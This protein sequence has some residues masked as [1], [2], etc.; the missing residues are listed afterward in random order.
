MSVHDQL[1]ALYRVD[2]Q[3]SG[4]SGRIDSAKR[5]LRTQETKLAELTRT[6]ED[7]LSRQRQLKATVANYEAEIKGFDA[8]IAHL[9]DQMNE[10]KTNREYTAFLTEM[11]TF[12]TDRGAIEESALEEMS[13]VEAIEAEVLKI[14]ELVLERTKLRDLAVKEVQKR[15]AD[16]ADRLAEL[17]AERELK[18]QEVPF[19]QREQYE[20]A[21]RDLEEP[22]A[23]IVEV[24]R[25]RMEFSCGACYMALTAETFNSLMVGTKAVQCETCGVILYVEP[26][27]AE[28]LRK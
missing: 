9:R 26:E 22:M 3:I 2:Q 11:N 19:A 6:K 21:R 15:E 8:K 24:N 7:L 1:L 20:L 25:R 12:K 14:D 27:L 10:A 16:A 17:R 4:L 23:P 5:H 28:T 18:A 13:R